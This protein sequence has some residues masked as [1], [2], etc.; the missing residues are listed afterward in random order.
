MDHNYLVTVL[1]YITL[2]VGGYTENIADIDISACVY[3][4]GTVDIGFFRYIDR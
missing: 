1:L 3:R 4:I 2:E